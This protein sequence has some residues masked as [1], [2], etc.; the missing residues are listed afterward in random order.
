MCACVHVQCHFC[1]LFTA[2]LLACFTVGTFV[3]LASSAD[4]GALNCGS[5]LDIAAPSSFLHVPFMLLAV[6]SS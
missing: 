2:H 6:S 5:G 4:V 1:F 3:M